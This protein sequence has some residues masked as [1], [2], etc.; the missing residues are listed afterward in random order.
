MSTER[1]GST[2]HP[3]EKIGDRIKHLRQQAGY[4]TASQFAR[5]HGLDWYT[6][7]RTEANQRRVNSDEVRFYRKVLG[8]RYED[9]LD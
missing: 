8:C 5:Y 6:H 3:E 4:E 1:T 2:P 9:L 7:L